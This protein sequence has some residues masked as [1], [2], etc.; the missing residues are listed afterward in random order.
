M[1]KSYSQMGPWKIWAEGLLMPRSFSWFGA[2]PWSDG[3]GFGWIRSLL[4][5][6]TVGRQLVRGHFE[7][8]S[9]SSL[10][11]SGILKDA[12]TKALVPDQSLMW[13]GT[14]ASTL[15]YDTDIYEL[16]SSDKV[17]IIREDIE[18]LKENSIML[19][20]GREIKTDALICATGYDY[21]PS[22]PLEP[23]SKQLRWGVPIPPSQDT[24]FPT[25]D[26][27]ADLE[28]FNRFPI[29]STSPDSKERQPGLTP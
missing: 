6:T 12:K 15:T 21:G 14:Q 11:Q 18:H 25:L 24:V 7:S 20:D 17:E 3:D 13:Y 22:F 2:C 1:A 27:K 19:Q 5:G 4:H 16:V 8:M 9:A 23:S 10:H 28:L 29:L 26:A